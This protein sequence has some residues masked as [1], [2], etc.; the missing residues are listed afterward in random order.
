M[1]LLT[2]EQIKFMRRLLTVRPVTRI[3]CGGW[4]ANEAKVDQTTEM[5]S[6]FIYFFKWTLVNFKFGFEFLNFFFYFFFA[7]LI[8]DQHTHTKNKDLYK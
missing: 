8:L 7:N 6:L 5:Y 4:G 2:S 1:I 3:L